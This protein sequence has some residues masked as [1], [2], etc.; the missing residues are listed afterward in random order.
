MRERLTAE[1]MVIPPY[2]D[3]LR[4]SRAQLASDTTICLPNSMKASRRPFTALPGNGAS[5]HSAKTATS[6][7]SAM[8]RPGAFT[9]NDLYPPP[10][11]AI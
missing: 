9:I 6:S 3:S 1:A 2:F 10:P 11:A 7:I 4:F 5:D 8:C